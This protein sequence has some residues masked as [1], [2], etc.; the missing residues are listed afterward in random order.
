VSLLSISVV[1]VR[2]SFLVVGLNG[3]VSLVRMFVSVGSLVI[4]RGDRKIVGLVY[5]GRC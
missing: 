4:G 2:K 1:S 5:N 3:S